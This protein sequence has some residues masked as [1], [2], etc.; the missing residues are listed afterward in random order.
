M[1]VVQ[2]REYC[3]SN[4]LSQCGTKKVLAKRTK[5][6][7]QSQ[8]QAV[9]ETRKCFLVHSGETI[10]DSLCTCEPNLKNICEHVMAVLAAREK[11]VIPRQFR[12]A[13]IS[14]KPKRGRK[15]LALP[16]LAKQQ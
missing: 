13:Y 14:V 7:F 4:K 15:A 12:N 8:P 1:K 5:D 2:L 3:K 9:I 16:A 11:L 10:T 6:F